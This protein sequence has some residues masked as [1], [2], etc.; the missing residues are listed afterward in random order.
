MFLAYA[1]LWQLWVAHFEHIRDITKGW[2]VE[3]IVVTKFAERS[4][5]AAV[6]FGRWQVSSLLL[7]GA[8]MPWTYVYWESISS[9]GDLR[10]IFSAIAIHLAW[11]VSWL[12]LSLPLIR[13]WRQWVEFRIRALNSSFGK[14]AEDADA[15][16]IL[17][18]FIDASPLSTVQ[19]VGASAGAFVSFM[20][21]I[22]QLFL[23]H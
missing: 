4:S 3:P 22:A 10:Y 19:I 7:A 8:F 14:P 15:E 18:L 9:W 5:I 16:R 12:L 21:P 23:K 6:E 1:I 13:V 17:R 11:G 20:L 2:S